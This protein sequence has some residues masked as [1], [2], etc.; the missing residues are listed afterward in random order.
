MVQLKA[1]DKNKLPWTER[2]DSFAITSSFP[3]ASAIYAYVFMW[4]RLDRLLLNVSHRACSFASSIFLLEFFG[5][6]AEGGLKRAMF[7]FWIIL[8]IFFIF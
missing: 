7:A 4:S 6:H 8:V 2:R 5:G 1:L 3:H